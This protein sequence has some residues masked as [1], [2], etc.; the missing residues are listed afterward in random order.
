MRKDLARVAL[1]AAVSLPA[2]LV[3]APALQSA[4]AHAR[5]DPARPGWHG[6]GVAPFFAAPSR[7]LP[8]TE[9]T[10]AWQTTPAAK[11]EAVPLAQPGEPLFADSFTL[12]MTGD[13]LLHQ[14]L[15]A[16]ARSDGGGRPDFLPMFSGIRRVISG[17]DLAL[18]HLE[19][20][21]APRRGPF[22]GY[23]TFSAPPQV[24]TAI[25]RIGYDG[26]STASNHTVDKGEPGVIR[27]LQALDRAGLRYAGSARTADEARLITLYNANG[28]QVAHLSYTYGT[29]GLPLPPRKPWMVNVGLAPRKIAAAA[30]RARREGADVVVVSLHWGEEYRHAPTAEQRRVA[31]ALL[32]SP[33]VDLVVGHHAHVVQP[34]ERIGDKWVAY[35]LGNQVANPS[36]G[37]AAT[38]EGAIAWFRFERTA[39]GWRVHP[40]FAPTKIGAG[41]PIRLAVTRSPSVAQVVRSLGERVPLLK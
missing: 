29:N 6:S 12:A 21:L 15:V 37:I 19:T 28:V 17:A 2:G 27:T 22:S 3:G 1:L 8:G 36:A 4:P 24:V 31:R 18:C 32:G 7:S 26:C 35:G 10:V 34:F 14:P 5:T 39:D 13:I 25:K 40:S 41:P 9:T 23:P 38:H 11:R 30:A 20:P 33:S 16:Q